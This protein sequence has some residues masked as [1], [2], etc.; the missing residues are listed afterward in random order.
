MRYKIIPFVFLLLAFS[1]CNE[2]FNSNSIQN[3][4]SND[5]SFVLLCKVKKYEIVDIN[6]VVTISKQSLTYQVNPEENGVERKD[7]S[8]K[9]SDEILQ[10]HFIENHYLD[11][12]PKKPELYRTETHK[13]L[14]NRFSGEYFDE[15]RNKF[16]DPISETGPFKYHGVCTKLE[17][18]F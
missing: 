15:Q 9:I 1:G 8:F 16:F 18:K 17:K 7:L 13:I 2:N 11:I 4:F 10:I 6:Y 3:F 12:N 14:I 5:E